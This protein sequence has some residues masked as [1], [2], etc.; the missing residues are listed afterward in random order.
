MPKTPA[1]QQIRTT[2]R[3]HPRHPRRH[4]APVSRGGCRSGG[5]SASFVRPVNPHG[6]Q[7]GHGKVLRTCA[8]PGSEGVITPGQL[9]G[10]RRRPDGGAGSARRSCHPASYRP[11][12]ASRPSPS[13][14][15]RPALTPRC[16][17]QVMARGGTT[18]RCER[19]A[20]RLPAAEG[21]DPAS[22]DQQARP[23]STREKPDDHQH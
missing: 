13:G 7:R 17:R 14:G 9:R 18:D 15:L 21:S 3:D 12:L 11:Q 16:V 8:R 23:A 6:F 4:S 5:W 10:R 1:P 19:S 20:Q 2:H 22:Q